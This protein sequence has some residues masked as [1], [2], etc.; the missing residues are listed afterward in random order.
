MRLFLVASLTVPSILLLVPS[1]FAP[2]L[3]SVDGYLCVQAFK[4]ISITACMFAFIAHEKLQEGN[5]NIFGGSNRQVSVA[6]VPAGDNGHNNVV[7]S[8]SSSNSNIVFDHHKLGLKACMT[9]VTYMLYELFW[10]Y[11]YTFGGSANRGLT[12]GAPLRVTGAFCLCLSFV[13]VT[14]TRKLELNTNRTNQFAI[15]EQFL[16]FQVVVCTCSYIA[17]TTTHLLL[18]MT[19]LTSSPCFIHL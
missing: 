12:A 7:G 14:L 3:A 1:T 11:S 2:G 10:L 19:I 9:L 4:R 17:L 15:I 5:S 16:S 13:Q 18:P 8:S 6:V